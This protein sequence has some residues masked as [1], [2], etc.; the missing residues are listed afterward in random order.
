MNDVSIHQETDTEQTAKKLY[1]PQAN[2][3]E[4]FEYSTLGTNIW[5]ELQLSQR[6]SHIHMY[7]CDF[8]NQQ[9]Y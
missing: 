5:P 7:V 1:S 2:I 3:T 6:V 8:H 4:L 9:W